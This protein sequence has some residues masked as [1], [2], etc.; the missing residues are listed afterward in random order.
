MELYNNV[1]IKVSVKLDL[2]YKNSEFQGTTSKSFDTENYLKAKVKCSLCKL[3]IS[4]FV[5]KHLKKK[6]WVYSNYYKYIITYQSK[7][8]GINK[9]GLQNETLDNFIESCI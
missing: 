3:P 1:N 7:K 9:L 5:E 8:E 2:N 6:I 4:L